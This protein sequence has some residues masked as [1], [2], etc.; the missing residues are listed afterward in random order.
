MNRTIAC[1]IL[2]V[3]VSAATWAQNAASD[4][5]GNIQT[6]PDYF[7]VWPVLKQRSLDFKVRSLESKRA[8]RY[9]PNNSYN[10]GLGAYVFDVSV[11]LSFAIPLNEKNQS[12]FGE[13]KA[14]DFQLNTLGRK[15]GI[16]L[17]YQKYSG[18]YTDNDLL[19]PEGSPY[20]HRSDISTRNVGVTALYVFNDE[21]FSIQSAFNFAE[22]QK[23]SAGSFLLTGTVNGFKLSADGPV[24]DSA[25]QYSYGTGKSFSELYLTTFS[26]APGY[27]YNF[28]RRNFFLSGALMLGPAH[29]WIHYEGDDMKPVYDIKFNLFTS[30]RVGVGY[31]A[32]RFFAGLKFV[33]QSRMA[34]FSDIR[35]TNSTSSF[36]L[37]VGYRFREVGVLK[38]SVWDLPKELLN[39]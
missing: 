30:F 20:F 10:V 21:D 1:L 29:N 19:I 5:T 4:P 31:N 36:R 39:L 9:Q 7:F 23:E 32:D 22:R 37:L 27:A 16:D 11:E 35:F 17:F 8:I 18:F 33:E 28:I 34:K 3:G 38:R 26:I 12:I 14:R 15:W 24:L 25:V 2:L 6:Y 13:S